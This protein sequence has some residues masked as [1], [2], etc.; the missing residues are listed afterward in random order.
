MEK[1]CPSSALGRV[2]VTAI[3]GQVANMHVAQGAAWEGLAAFF[4]DTDGVMWVEPL[5]MGSH[6]CP[7]VSST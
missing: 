7:C 4:Q 3:L 6:P 1:L 2:G 5:E